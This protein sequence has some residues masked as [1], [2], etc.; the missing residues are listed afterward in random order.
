MECP[1]TLLTGNEPSV[2]SSLIRG[3]VE[4]PRQVLRTKDRPRVGAASV[5]FGDVCGGRVI[6]EP[7]GASNFPAPTLSVSS[8]ASEISSCLD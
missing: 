5:A 8:R 6:G 3:G 7:G 1:I 4:L 2:G